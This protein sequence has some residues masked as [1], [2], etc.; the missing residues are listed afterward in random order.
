MKIA[1][2]VAGSAIAAGLL[3]SAAAAAGDPPV[4]TL[5]RTPCFGMCP[6]Y[7]VTLDADGTVTYVGRSNVRVAGQQTWKI[8]PAS[9]DALASEMEK[10]GYFKLKDRYTAPITDQPTTR[11]SLRFRRHHKEITDYYGGPDVLKTLE[12]RIDEVAGVKRFVFI[13]GATL[14]SMAAGGWKPAG[15]E[16]D[17]WMRQAAASGDAEVVGALID[18]GYD[19]RAAESAP[20]GSGLLLNVRGDG[21]ARLL[22]DAGANA[23]AVSDRGWTPLH[24]ACVRSDAPTI[25][26]LLAAG[27]AVNVRDDG[28]TT[29][30]IAC[31][32]AGSLEGVKAL[33]T[34]GADPKAQ[35]DHRESAADRARLGKK[36]AADLAFLRKPGAPTPPFDEI[37]ALLEK[38]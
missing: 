36:Q 22:V 9:V 24:A 13:D 15:K 31:A 27:A 11:T 12:R 16:A 32:G 18:L 37:V 6:A 33:L 10:A 1:T 26:V 38:R 7:S 19:V 34:A 8:S 17:D 23:N 29:P 21:I 20:G 5:E 25:S 35:D 4:V 28:G 30:L 3:A 2:R 14:R